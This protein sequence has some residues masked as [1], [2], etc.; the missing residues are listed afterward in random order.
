[1]GGGGPCCDWDFFSSNWE[2]S[3]LICIGNGALFRPLR[4]P[5]KIPAHNLC[6]GAKIRNIGIPLQTPAFLYKS[7]VQG[8]IHHVFVMTLTSEPLDYLVRPMMI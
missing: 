7:G 6:F 5:K 4:H 8:G 3:H 2:K 1:M